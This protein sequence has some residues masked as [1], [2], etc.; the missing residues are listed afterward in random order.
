MGAEWGCPGHG[1]N[2]QCH[3]SPAELLEA[4]PH[5]LWPPLPRPLSRRQVCPLTPGPGESPGAGSHHG[6]RGEKAAPGGETRERLG[7]ASPEALALSFPPWQLQYEEEFP[8]NLGTSTP[9]TPRPASHLPR[10]LGWTGPSCRMAPLSPQS[11]LSSRPRVDGKLGKEEE[12]GSPALAR[13]PGLRIYGRTGRD[14][15]KP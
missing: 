9:S 6:N 11:P 2:S 12:P 3:L 15:K 13:G 14:I 7:K 10:R 1:P 4:R 5:C 8:R